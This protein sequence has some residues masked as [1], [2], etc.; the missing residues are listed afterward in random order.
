MRD[1]RVTQ[2]ID[3]HPMFFLLALLVFIVLP[4]PWGVIGGVACVALFIGEV[5][6]WQRRMRGAKVQTGVENLVGAT[7]EVTEAL[8]PSGKVRVLGELWEARSSSELPP[9]SPVRVVA[10][11]GL[12]LEVEAAEEQAGTPNPA[13]SPPDSGA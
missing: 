5:G 8:A 6:Y 11:H 7:G 2:I 12:I 13:V 1:S 9:G 4:S 10:L 3:G